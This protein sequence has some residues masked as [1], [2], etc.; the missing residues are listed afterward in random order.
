[1]LDEW[2]H[3]RGVRL[4]F[5]APGRPIQNAFAE[6][7]NGKLREEC[8]NENCFVDLDD[9]QAKIESWRLDYNAERPRGTLAL[10]HEWITNIQQNPG[11][12]V[13]ATS[14]RQRA[15]LRTG[16]CCTRAPTCGPAR[17]RTAGALE[18]DPEGPC[19][20]SRRA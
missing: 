10:L 9:A 17:R 20:R 2:A 19:P 6:S 5:I 12:G 18:D 7:F 13:A 3:R 1:V 16:T 11:L 15:S 14:R 8:L 4:D